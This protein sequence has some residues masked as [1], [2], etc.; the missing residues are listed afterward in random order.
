[1]IPALDT[2]GD[3]AVALGYEERE[4]DKGEVTKAEIEERR[5]SGMQAS[6]L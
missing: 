3:P 1:M 5:A 4:S 6:R 2:N